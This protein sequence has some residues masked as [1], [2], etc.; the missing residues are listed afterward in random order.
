[1]RKPLQFALV[2]VAVLLLGTTA[3]LFQKYRTSE[4]QYTSLKNSEEATRS[5]YGEAIDEIAMIQDSL[6]AI[7]LGDS[8][9]ALLPSSLQAEAHLTETQGDRAL[10]RIAVLKA[11]IQRT[12]DRIEV[13]D[14]NLKHSGVKIA[15]LNRMIGNLKKSVAEKEQLVAELTT[16]VDSLQTTVTGLASEV[17][18]NQDTIQAQAQTIEDKQHELGTIYYVIGNKKDLTTAGVVEAKGGILGLG[19]TLKPTGKFDQSLFTELDTDQ[20]QVIP[21][22]AAK[23]QV[24]SPQPVSSYALDV[25]DGK[26]ELRILDPNEFRKVK[27]L[28][29]MTAV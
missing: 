9:V 27:Y 16:R 4:A 5:R 13:L 3:V 23:A 20:E 17:Q 15:G 10:A 19:K 24:L 21:I 1:M 28:V 22:S 7:V 14:A 6:N 12:K 25:V 18:E 29:I 8:A 26:V 11:G 2:A